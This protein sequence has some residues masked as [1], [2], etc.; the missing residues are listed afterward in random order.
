MFAFAKDGKWQ[1]VQLSM[2]SVGKPLEHAQA[3][4]QDFFYCHGVS[5]ALHE[6]DLLPSRY[7]YAPNKSETEDLDDW[8]EVENLIDLRAKAVWAK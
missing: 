4:A 5:Q 8:F 2:T 3:Q 7:G 1:A 6:I